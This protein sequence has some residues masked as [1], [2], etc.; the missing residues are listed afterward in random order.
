MSN[1]TETYKKALMSISKN[2]CCDNCQE[3]AMVATNALNK[4][5]APCQRVEGG[6]KPDLSTTCQRCKEN[7]AIMY[8]DSCGY[9]R[10][11]Q[12]C[13]EAICYE[14]ADKRLKENPRSGLVPKFKAM[15]RELGK[16]DDPHIE[17][18]KVALETVYG[19][20]WDYE[21]AKEH[22]ARVSR[23]IGKMRENEDNG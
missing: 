17:A 14:N 23:A 6:F 10:L 9:N 13:W 12:N 19:K 2:R 8:I 16:Q 7:P 3:A 20:Q 5:S 11:C 22:L 18:A 15:L 21:L 4:Y 1:E